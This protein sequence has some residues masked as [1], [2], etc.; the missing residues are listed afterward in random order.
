MQRK[1]EIKVTIVALSFIKSL[2]VHFKDNYKYLFSDNYLTLEK[3]QTKTINIKCDDLINVSEI[4][5]DCLLN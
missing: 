1:L 3:G 4:R 2:F 5:L